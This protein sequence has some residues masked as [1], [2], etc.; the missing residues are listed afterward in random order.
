TKVKIVRFSYPHEFPA[1]RQTE[2]IMPGFGAMLARPYLNDFSRDYDVALWLDADVWVQE[3]DAIEMLVSE[4]ARH[5]IAAIPEVDRS[6]FKLTQAFYVWNLE[7]QIA[8]RIF[9]REIAAKMHLVPTI[10]VGVLAIQ[11]NS[12]VWNKWR[13]WLQ[14][15]LLRIPVID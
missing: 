9:G 12:V 1:K 15:G 10:N 6:Y 4:A 8:E 2:I 5:G 11:S 3:P 7:A 14:K 13:E